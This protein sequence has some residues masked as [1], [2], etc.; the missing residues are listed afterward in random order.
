MAIEIEKKFRLTPQQS[1]LVRASLIRL[2]AEYVGE[3]LEENTIYGG[4]ALDEQNAVVRIRRTADSSVLTFKKRIGSELPVKQ[5]IEHESEVSDAE[6][7]A[8][9]LD[10]IG[11]ERRLI[12]EKRRRKWRF[13]S[14]EVVLDELPFGLFMEIEGPL[15]AIAEAEM[16]LDVDGLEPEHETYPRLTQRFGV[17]RGNIV[18]AR[19]GP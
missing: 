17:R 6:A 16:L 14:V 13:R 19:F 7:I 15:T 4:P 8:A 3:D 10:S 2:E 1:E 5:Q 12:Y 11:L 9:I 18:E